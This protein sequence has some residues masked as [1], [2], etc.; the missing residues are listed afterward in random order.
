MDRANEKIERTQTWMAASPL[1]VRHVGHIVHSFKVVLI[2][3]RVSNSLFS[4]YH[5]P[6]VS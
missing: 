5:N 3:F 1:S 6:N 4:Q 2:F